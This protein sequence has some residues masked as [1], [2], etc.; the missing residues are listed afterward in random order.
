M[1]HR[2][3]L[4]AAISLALVILIVVLLIPK[5]YQAKHPDRLTA[6][7]L[8]G[9]MV[10]IIV[11][12][13]RARRGIIPYVRRIGGISAIEEAIGRATEMGKPIVY[14]AGFSDITNVVTHVSLAVLS[15]VARLAARLGTPLIACISIPNVYPFAEEVIREAFKEEGAL[16]PEPN[17]YSEFVEVQA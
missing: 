7:L 14:V 10:L 11:F 1:K 5:E 17:S 15:H 4:T 3:I 16:M 9:F 13:L 2:D 6:I 12:L 8:L